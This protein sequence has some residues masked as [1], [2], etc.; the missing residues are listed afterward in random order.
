MSSTAAAVRR[1]APPLIPRPWLN[2]KGEV[3]EYRSVVFA[4]LLLPAL[5]LAWE[6]WS[7]ALGPEPLKAAM[8]DMGEWTLRLVLITLL[9]TPLRTICDWPTVAY[10]RR[11]IGVGTAC[12]AVAH[13]MLY[14]VHQNFHL[15]RV[16]KEIALRPYL[17]IGFI[18][19]A[20]LVALAWTSTDGWSKR[21][22]KNWKK[23]H[24][25]IYPVAALGILHFFIQSKADVSEPVFVSGLFI[26]LLTFRLLPERW[27]GH[28][29]TPFALIPAAGIGAAFFEFLWCLFATNFPA[30]LVL[31][32]NLDLDF[33]PRPA[34][35]SA[36]AALILAVVASTMRF[37][38]EAIARLRQA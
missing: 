35:W 36:I 22:G 4:L 8:R 19:L 10:L 6:W 18:A 26:W 25:L 1:P 14:V 30:F 29:A 17:T 24:K 7:G 11:L 33:G 31:E 2:R 37:G 23:L 12:Y 16:V 38:P 5:F 20:G 32:A 9:V 3:C 27:Q 15:W 21:L 34:V 28:W 13:L